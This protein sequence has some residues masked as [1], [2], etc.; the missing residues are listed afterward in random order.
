MLCHVKFKVRIATLNIATLSGHEALQT[1][2]K[3]IID[4]NLGFRAS[5]LV[6]KSVLSPRSNS[7]LDLALKQTLGYHETYCIMLN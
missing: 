4:F 3:P 2:A 6:T 1:F 7:H 5:Y